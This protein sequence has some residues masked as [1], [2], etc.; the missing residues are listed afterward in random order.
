M[1]QHSG[2]NHPVR[3]RRLRHVRPRRVLGDAAAARRPAVAS[4]TG[5]GAAANDAYPHLPVW[6]SSHLVPTCL[7]CGRSSPPYVVAFFMFMFS[8]EMIHSLSIVSGYGACFEYTLINDAA[9]IFTSDLQPFILS[10]F[11]LSL[12]TNMICTSKSLALVPLRLPLRTASPDTSF[13]SHDHRAYYVVKPPRPPIPC[14]S[15]RCNFSMGRH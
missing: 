11:A 7:S 13:L 10:F 12:S 2:E 5:G 3:Q 4:T 1:S 15:V 8:N 9:D 14:R 6:I